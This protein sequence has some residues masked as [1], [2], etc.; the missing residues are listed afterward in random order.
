MLF[1]REL[2]ISDWELLLMPGQSAGFSGAKEITGRTARELTLALK[3]ADFTPGLV[4]CFY[5]FLRPK[6]SPFHGAGKWRPPAHEYGAV[7]YQA[8]ENTDRDAIGAS[9][10]AAMSGEAVIKSFTPSTCQSS[11]YRKQ[12]DS[13]PK[14]A[15]NKSK[16]CKQTMPIPR[17]QTH[18]KHRHHQTGPNWPNAFTPGRAV[19]I[20]RPPKNHA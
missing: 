16:R 5:R 20:G 19:R 17:Q 12:H 10:E 9:T 13:Q 7:R 3:N 2:G 4:S 15:G 6:A 11:K 14:E 18:Q 1:H 8:R